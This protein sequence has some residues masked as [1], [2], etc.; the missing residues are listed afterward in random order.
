MKKILI[1]FLAAFFCIICHAQS[2]TI[3]LDVLDIT[4]EGITL[5]KE[6]WPCENIYKSPKCFIFGYNYFK[7][8]SEENTPTYSSYTVEIKGKNSSSV[9][10][11]TYDQRGDDVYI[12]FAGY[13]FKCITSKEGKYPYVLIDRKPSFMGGDANSFSKWVNERLE[14]PEIAKENGYQGRVT[15]SFTIK[16][17][18]K[19][20][21]VK[22]LHGVHPALDAEAVRVVSMSPKW[23]PGKLNG[24]KVPVTYTFPVIFQLR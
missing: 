12:H 13:S 19:I 1:S 4:Y 9:A 2:Q 10:D 18:G 6:Q 20:A 22:V 15:L 14:Y 24:K 3:Q 23:K 5:P 16:K 8:L 17:N 7:I 11:L 21:D